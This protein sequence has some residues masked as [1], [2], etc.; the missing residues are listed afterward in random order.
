M[1]LGGMGT[2]WS[3][4]LLFQARCELRCPDAFV[5][6]MLLGDTGESYLSKGLPT[7][8]GCELFIGDGGAGDSNG[9]MFTHAIV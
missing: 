2:T 8:A 7:A 1:N 9:D 5:L 4:T 6:G 3:E